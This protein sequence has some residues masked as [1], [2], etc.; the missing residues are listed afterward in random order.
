MDVLVI[1][2]VNPDIIMRLKRFP[3]RGKQEITKNVL[4]K[5]GGSA[6]N[7]AVA[8][9]RLGL[10][11]LFIGSVGNDFF[12][13][14]CLE[15]LR[16]AG[17]NA[18]MRLLNVHT[19]FT[20]AVEDPEERTMFTFRGAN[21]FLDIKHVP[22]APWVHIS[23]YWHLTRLRPKIV[24]IFRQAKEQGA[25]TSF[26]F[27]S[28]TDDW[29][30]GK[31]LKE[32][33]ESRLIDFFFCDEEELQAFT[34]MDLESA[35]TYAGKYTALGIHMG[36]KGALVVVNGDRYHVPTRPLKIIVKTGA[37]DTW[38]AGFIWGYLKTKDPRRA[39]EIGMA[40][41][42]HYLETGEVVPTGL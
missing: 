8:L 24:D 4:L 18:N 14:F 32:A 11:V 23:G 13:S 7:T 28:W 26:D 17:V 9:S 15:E 1:G 34:G 3:N 38:N 31:Y 25:L 21:E 36:K 30:E 22:P 27:G 29:S 35:I 33:L 6:A 5:I 10:S 37:G 16:K 20:V 19:G 12:G 2:D 41:V 39:G 42:Q 40:V